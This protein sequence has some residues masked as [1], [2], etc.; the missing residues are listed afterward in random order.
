MHY[1]HNFVVDGFCLRGVDETGIEYVSISEK[2]GVFAFRA[3]VLKMCLI[4]TES[5]A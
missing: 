1:G 2:R 3:S 5:C 4:K